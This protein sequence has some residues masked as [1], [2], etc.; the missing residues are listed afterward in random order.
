METEQLVIDFNKPVRL[1]PL[2]SCVLLPHAT[3]PLHVFEPRY[4]A[5]LR[6]ALDSDGIIG[7]AVFAGDDWKHDYAGNP[8]L[9]PCVAVGYLAQDQRLDD[10]RHNIL[11]H[12]ICRAEIQ[13]EKPLHPDGYRLAKLEPFGH[14]EADGETQS[15]LENARQRIADLLGDPYLSRL[16]IISSIQEWLEDDIP[17]PAF[18]ELAM[19]GLSQDLEERYAMLAEADVVA[20]ARLVEAQLRSMRDLVKRAEENAG[21]RDDDGWS[22]N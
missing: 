4:R 21:G 12:G 19:L 6:D 13:E 10:G 2:Q 9:R 7:M 3:V 16:A 1:F 22:L 17:T 15:G 14:P 5:M 11:L 18:I 20:R 8:P